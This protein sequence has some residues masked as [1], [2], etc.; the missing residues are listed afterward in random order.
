[1]I[2]PS[3]C[4]FV[5]SFHLVAAYL[6]LESLAQTDRPRSHPKATPHLRLSRIPKSIVAY[7][8]IFQATTAPPLLLSRCSLFMMKMPQT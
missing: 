2:E 6:N 3:T 8:P 1:M 7:F 5:V 4:N